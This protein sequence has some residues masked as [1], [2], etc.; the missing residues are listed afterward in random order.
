MTEP[1]DLNPFRKPD[2]LDA[3]RGICIAVVLS[4]SV[5]LIA[6][7]LARWGSS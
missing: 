4:I 2:D 1:D 3:A 6:Y 5:L 7:V